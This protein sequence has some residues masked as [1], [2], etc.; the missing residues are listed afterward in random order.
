MAVREREG[1]DETD[2][3]IDDLKQQISSH[4]RFTK[5]ATTDEMRINTR[6]ALHFIR[7]IQRPTQPKKAIPTRDPFI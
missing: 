2:Y 5:S 6:T 1:T 4:D 3:R 7:F